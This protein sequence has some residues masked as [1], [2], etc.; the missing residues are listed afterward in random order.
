MGLIDNMADNWRNVKRC[1]A[2]YYIENKRPEIYRLHLRALDNEHIH[3]SYFD[4]SETN[5]VHILH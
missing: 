4:K 3:I 5:N 1:E 2:Y